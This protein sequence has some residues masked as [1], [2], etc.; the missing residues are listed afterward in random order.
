MDKL[1]SK[2]VRLS[3][4]VEVTDNYKDTSLL[5]YGTNYG[6]NKFYGTGPRSLYYKALQICNV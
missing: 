1:C 5:R 2:L 4:A 6:R 3:K